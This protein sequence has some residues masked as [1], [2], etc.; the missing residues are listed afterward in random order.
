MTKSEVVADVAAVDGMVAPGLETGTGL[1][2]EILKLLGGAAVFVETAASV[3]EFSG[4]V[5]LLSIHSSSSVISGT[6][7]SS[8]LSPAF[9]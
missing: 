9:M 8:L 2:L 4:S 3:G 1:E 6:I 5:M 7:F